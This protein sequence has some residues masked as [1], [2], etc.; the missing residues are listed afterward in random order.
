[1]ADKIN[2]VD[3]AEAAADM[4]RDRVVWR[5]DLDEWWMCS[6]TSRPGVWSKQRK[7][8]V[9]SELTRIVTSL[10]PDATASWRNG[11]EVYLRDKLAVDGHEFDQDPWLLCVRNGVVDLQ[12]GELLPRAP[13]FYMTRYAIYDYDRKAPND[14]WIAHLN[15][16]FDSDEDVIHWLKLALGQ[17]L[18]GKITDKEPMFLWVFGLS[19]TGKTKLLE[20]IVDI[21]GDYAKVLHP[22]SIKQRRGDIHTSAL[23]LD[24]IRLALVDEITRGKTDTD[25]LKAATGS[26]TAQGQPGMGKDFRHYGQSATLVMTANWPLPLSSEDIDGLERRYRPVN[27]TNAQLSRSEILAAI[28]RANN[29]CSVNSYREMLLTQGSGI[30]TWL[31]DGAVEW[32]NSGRVLDNFEPKRLT[33]LRESLL[34]NAASPL[35]DWVKNEDIRPGDVLVSH[36]EVMAS[37]RAQ[38]AANEVEWPSSH[39]VYERL[40]ALGCRE[41]EMKVYKPSPD[42]S[43]KSRVTKRFFLLA[44]GLG[45]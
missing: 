28:T 34:A 21:L 3:V 25:F 41:K 22:A 7:R 24:G 35:D 23:N 18:I 8:G 6:Q 4:L 15:R 33:E 44:Q 32:A 10:K 26:A 43:K 38:C 13:N 11:V 9:L 17:A 40:R 20:A 42:G 1:M 16:L 27:A 30:L 29:T 31:I 2:Q 19:K 14:I 5:S 12:T 39:S 45:Q 36:N 37:V